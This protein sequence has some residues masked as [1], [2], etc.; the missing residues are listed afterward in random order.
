MNWD[1]KQSN[2]KQVARQAKHEAEK[3]VAEW[4]SEATHSW[5]ATNKDGV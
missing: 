2:R 5:F 3:Q 1:R 4:Q